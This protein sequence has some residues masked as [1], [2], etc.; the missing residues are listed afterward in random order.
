MVEIITDAVSQYVTQ[1]CI[2]VEDAQS[3]TYN[4]IHAHMHT[5]RQSQYF[6]TSVT[7]LKDASYS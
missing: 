7:A 4:M 1:P 3:S 6:V 2:S 5:T